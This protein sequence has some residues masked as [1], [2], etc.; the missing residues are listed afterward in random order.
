MTMVPGREA[1]GTEV[2]A[3]GLLPMGK[4][5]EATKVTTT[6]GA[7]ITPTLWATRFTT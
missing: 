5:M 2:E 3:V 6:Q 7:A 1:V 4:T